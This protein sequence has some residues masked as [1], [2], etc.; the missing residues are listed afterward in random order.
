MLRRF[1]CA[2]FMR[3]ILEKT[4]STSAL[5][6][7]RTTSLANRSDVRETGQTLSP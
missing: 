6:A 1:H 2:V 7:G 5:T 3:F 4:L